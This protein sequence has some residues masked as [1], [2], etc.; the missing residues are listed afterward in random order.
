MLEEKKRVVVIGVGNLLLG[1][2]GVGIRV[3]NI[4]KDEPFPSSITFI[5][6]GTAGIDLLF[7][8]EGADY[9][10]IID[11]MEGSAEP[12]TVFRLP[13]DELFPKESGNIASQHEVGLQE[14]LFMAKKTGKLPPAVIYGV[15]PKTVTPSDQLSPEVNR[16]IPRLLQLIRQEINSLP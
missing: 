9:A 4:L 16:S 11:C 5:D 2:E 10:V 8:L 12:G 7:F 1:D 14:V 3:I 6:G 15:Q 13:A